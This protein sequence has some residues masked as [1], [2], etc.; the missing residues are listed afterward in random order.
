MTTSP[1]QKQE[2]KT[3]SELA[4]IIET[5]LKNS[6]W[7]VFKEVKPKTGTHIADIV[8]LKNGEIVII[9]TKLHYG[10]QVL[11]QAHNWLKVAHRIYVGVPAN[12]YSNIVL[13]HFLRFHGIGQI[14]VFS[15]TENRPGYCRINIE[16]KKVEP[17]YK[18][19]ILGSLHI[20][21][22]DSI[23]G[24]K[25]GGH[26]TP[27]SL[28]IDNI[29]D[30]LKNN[31]PT[32]IEEIVKNITHHYASQSNAV[33]TLSKRLVEVETDFDYKMMGTKRVFFLKLNKK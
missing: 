18:A 3:E 25:G 9:E 2:F 23:A 12:N 6:G 16:A 14:L 8:A 15:P 17:E 21:Q 5:W 20:K 30:F 11:E 29:R 32:T 22:K 1:F 13:N 26:V 7:E 4:L 28:T 10:T 33:S 24:S 19:H 31:G 27:Y